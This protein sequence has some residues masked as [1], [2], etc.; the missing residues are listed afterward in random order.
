MALVTW[1][2][3]YSVNVK[4][5]DGHHQHLFDLLNELHDAMRSG[6]GRHLVGGIVDRLAD[7]ADRHFDA[8]EAMMRNTGYPGM[9]A[10][11]AQH[12]IYRRKVHDLERRFRTGS[13][14]ITHE[15]LDFLRDWLKEHIAKTDRGYGQHF[16]SRG[17]Q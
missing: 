1:N 4:L 7:Y 3:S 6:K 11:V 9:D 17:V 2:D 10:H 16:N 8:E 13:G 14:A 12:Q 5:F 15:V